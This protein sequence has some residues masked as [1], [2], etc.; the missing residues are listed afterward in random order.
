MIKNLTFLLFCV[1]LNAKTHEL[2][3]DNMGCA[4][5]AKKIE[6]AAKRRFKFKFPRTRT[7]F[8]SSSLVATQNLQP[9]TL[10]AS[11]KLNA[12]VPKPPS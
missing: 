3:V 12:S 4:S 8:A 6:N 7:L 5:C 9:F 1:A 11:L 10:I 2:N